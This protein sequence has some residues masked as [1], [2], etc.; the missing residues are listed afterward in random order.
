MKLKYI[1]TRYGPIIFPEAVTH[2]DAAKG[3]DPVHS[4]GFLYILWDEDNKR[5]DCQPFGESASLEIKSH[6]ESDKIK[7]DKMLN[8]F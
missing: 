7:L 1:V 8:Q 6:P 3:L 4:A 5:F 2:Y